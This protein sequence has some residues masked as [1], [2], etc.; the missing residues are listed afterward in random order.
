MNDKAGRFPEE[1]RLSRAERCL[2]LVYSDGGTVVLPAEYLRVHSPSAEV[3]G[4][5]GG[6]PKTIAG[7]REVAILRVE[8]VGNYALK[9]VFSDGH[10]T[11]IFT[12][13]YLYELGVDYDR[14][15]QAYLDRL[16]K[17]GLSR[18]PT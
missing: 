16:E 13:S 1:V 15:W 11:G 18:D 14:N 10:E 12:W 4:H 8:P 9:P 7:K 3:K 6:P 2:R 17:E 5:G